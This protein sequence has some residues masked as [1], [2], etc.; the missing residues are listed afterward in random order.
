VG[1]TGNPACAGVTCGSIRDAWPP[2]DG[3]GCWRARDKNAVGICAGWRDG[4]CGI[5]LAQAGL[6]VLLKGGTAKGVL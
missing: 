2:R 6:P 3:V 1:S 5:T 4:C